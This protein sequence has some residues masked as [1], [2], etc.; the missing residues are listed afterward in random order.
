MV[1]VPDL[2]WKKR[3]ELQSRAQKNV[4]HAISSTVNLPNDATKEDVAEIYLAAWKL[5]CKGMTVYRDGCR[6]GV[7]VGLDTSEDKTEIQYNDAPKRPK[8]IDADV[9]HLTYKKEPYFVFIGKIGDNEPYEIFA[10]KNGFISKD[11]KTA[12]IEKVKKG[13]YRAHLDDGNIVDDIGSHITD[14]QATITRMISL[15]L[16]HGCGVKH[17]VESLHKVEG[18]MQNFGRC[19]ARV[20]KQYIADGTE[21]SSYGEGTWVYQEGCVTNIETGESKCF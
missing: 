16:R 7:L 6:T 3:V 11:V 15:A 21:A 14:D 13:K 9:Y 12:T 2:D 10:G 18:D 1:R 20:L 8:E 4:D 17:A 19:V 5:G